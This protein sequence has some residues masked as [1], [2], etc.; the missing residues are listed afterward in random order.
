MKRFLLSIVL[1]WA[2][3]V[4]LYAQSNTPMPATDST[5]LYAKYPDLPAFNI[6]NKDSLSIFNTYYIP[7]GK[8]ILLIHFDPDCKH[9]KK[10]AHLLADSFKAISGVRMYW[11]TVNH[12]MQMI[13]DFYRDYG[14]A[15][16]KDMEM[17]GRDYEYFMAPYY[18]MKFIPGIVLYDENKKFVKLIDGDRLISDTREYLDT[19]PQAKH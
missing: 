5:P 9:C 10:V 14:F 6:L 1:L 15:K 17:M 2:G 16:Y 18:N 13:R 3:V 7:K 12:N 11:C 19:H 8:P 4:A